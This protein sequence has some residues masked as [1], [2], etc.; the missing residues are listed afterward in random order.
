M[1]GA[2]SP[3]RLVRSSVD[4]VLPSFPFR[5]RNNRS[6]LRRTSEVAARFVRWCPPPA[7]VADLGTGQ[8]LL[9]GVLAALGYKA[10]GIDD[11]GDPVHDPETVGLIERFAEEARFRLI[12]EKIEAFAPHEPLDGVA[13]M[14]VVEHMHDSPRDLLNHVG[15]MLKPGGVLVLA[16]PNSVNL[17]KRWDVVCGRTNYPPL[18]QF[19]DAPVPW[20]GHVREYTPSETGELLRLAGF[21]LLEARAFDAIL[22]DRV[23]AGLL[24]LGYLAVTALRPALKDSVLALGRKPASWKPISETAASP[25]ACEL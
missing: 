23:P 17:R 11:Y 25:V 14:D 4:R 20:R 8:A 12:R 6:L 13:L 15:A 18:R 21:E 9:P 16:M 22:F 1:I 19:F 10:M 5:D 3:G 7:T 24:R 2:E